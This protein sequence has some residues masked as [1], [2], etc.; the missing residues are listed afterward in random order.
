MYF[1]NENS[2]SLTT[3]IFFTLYEIIYFDG[4][5]YSQFF[6]ISFSDYFCPPRQQNVLIC[7]KICLLLVKH[8]SKA[9]AEQS[10]AEQSRAEQSRALNLASA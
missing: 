3:K 1:I 4:P 7:C 2:S 5:Q 9:K 6:L 10:R 8:K